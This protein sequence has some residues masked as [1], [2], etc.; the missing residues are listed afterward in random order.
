MMPNNTESLTGCEPGYLQQILDI[1]P[2]GVLIIEAPAGNFIVINQEMERIHKRKF[3]LPIGSDEYMEWRLFYIDGRPYELEDFPH[4]RSLH[5]GEVIKGEYARLLRSDNTTIPISVYSA[6]IYDSAGK[7]THV[8]IENT[9]ITE[10][11]RC[12]N[13][14]SGLYG[15]R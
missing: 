3:S 4:N 7:M 14:R 5:K 13:A 9:D 8:V 11:L 1:L 15:V 2:V 10:L 12:E 6:P